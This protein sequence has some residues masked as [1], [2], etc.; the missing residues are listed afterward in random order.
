MPVFSFWITHL[1]LH[2]YAKVL[3]LFL[4]HLAVIMVGQKRGIHCLIPK[5]EVCPSKFSRWVWLP[6]TSLT[7]LTSAWS[8]LE[9]MVAGL[10]STTQS[11]ITSWIITAV[12]GPSDS[13]ELAT[14]LLWQFCWPPHSSPCGMSKARLDHKQ[15]FPA[16][17]NHTDQPL[18][19]LLPPPL[20]LFP[21]PEWHSLK[22]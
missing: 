1:G 3:H 17:T 9:S 16:C 10:S 15:N 4:R 8:V 12:T 14:L 19:D 21:C 11:E 20:L 5:E 18:L 22:K 13:C 7:T 2:P 6:F